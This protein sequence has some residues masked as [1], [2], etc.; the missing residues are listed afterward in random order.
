MPL[1]RT[2]Q[3]AR[4]GRARIPTLAPEDRI[5]DDPDLCREPPGRRKCG[6]GT[7]RRTLSLVAD[8]MI[9]WRDMFETMYLPAPAM[10]DFGCEGRAMLHSQIEMFAARV[11]VL[12]PCVY[13]TASDAALLRTSRNTTASNTTSLESWMERPT[14]AS[15]G[16]LNLSRLLMPR[17]KG[18][19]SLS[20]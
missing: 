13:G 3:G 7:A 2:P 10:W 11:A 14:S 15:C 4:L 8:A 17:L 12:N 9:H 18:R 5:A 6:G 20:L 16:L 1:W 19:R